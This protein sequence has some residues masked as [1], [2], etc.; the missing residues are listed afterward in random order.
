MRSALLPLGLSAL[1]LAFEKS[2]RHARSTSSEVF[3]KRDYFYV[4]GNLTLKIV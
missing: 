2:H 1:A 4:G 3:A